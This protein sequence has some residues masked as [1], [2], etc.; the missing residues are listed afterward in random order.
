M[1]NLNKELSGTILPHD[2]FDTHLDNN[3]KTIDEELEL[4]NF[5]S[6]AEILAELGSKLVIDGHPVVAEFINEEPLDITVT[7]QRN[8]MQ[9]MSGDHNSFYKS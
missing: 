4:R 8:G 2:H 9:N 1:S 3:N 6:A 5:E 7:K